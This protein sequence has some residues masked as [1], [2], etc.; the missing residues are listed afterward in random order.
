MAKFKYVAKDKAGRTVKGEVEAADKKH[1]VEILRGKELLTLKLEEARRA[2]L[3]FPSLKL[4]SAGP[5]VKMDDIVVFTRQLATMTG[6]GI[7]ILT[8]LDTLGDQADNATLQKVLWD[9]R[10]SVNTGK[11]LSEAMG[12]HSAVFS[13]YFVNMVRAGESSG[14][15]DDVLDKVASY[16]EKTSA[17]HKK[18]KS[19]M[20]YPAVVTGMAVVITLVMILRVIPVFK[21]MFSGF[22]ATLPAPTQFLINLSDAMRHYFWLFVLCAA[23]GAFAMRWYVRTD[24]GRLAIDGLKLRLPVFGPLFRKVAVSKFTRTLSTL[25]KSGVPILS[26]LEIVAKT[27]G[28]MVVENAVNSVKESV[29]GGES[30]AGPMGKSGIFPPLVTRMVAVGEK[31]GQMETMLTKIA[32]FYDAQVDAAVETLTSLIEPFI[33]AFLGIVI[34]G[35]V[36]SMF[37]PIFKMSTLIAF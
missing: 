16:M 29:R 7:T 24:K 37:L 6:A 15:L 31:S 9:M 8:S 25:V 14:M 12:D 19:A 10:D 5:K 36:I 33:I 22:G 23:I 28:N 17:L 30:I 11:S 32:D 4:I 3:A 18:I 1:A 13:A 21:E 26:A 20:V 2:A 34:G 27:S 35:I